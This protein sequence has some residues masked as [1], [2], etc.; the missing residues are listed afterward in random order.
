MNETMYRKRATFADSNDEGAKVLI[1]D[2]D[3]AIV[4]VVSL[5]LRS[6]GH[7]PLEALRGR[8]GLEIAVN[9][10]PDL[11]LLDIM[12]PGIDGYEFYRRLR[13]DSRTAEI[14]VIFVTAVLGAESVE[15]GAEAQYLTKPFLPEQLLSMVLEAVG[16]AA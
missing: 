3:P 8:E 7:R 5:L 4:K 10:K 15:G 13:D 9:E 16:T 6:K 2:D 14:P 1:V 11:I 12:M